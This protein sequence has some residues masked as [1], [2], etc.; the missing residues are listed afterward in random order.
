MF[1]GLIEGRGKIRSIT[2]TGEDLN[3]IIAPLFDVTDCR[4]GDS[5]CV[6]G[7]CLTVTSV[8]QGI[9]SMYASEET[10]SRST[11]GGLKRGD[12]VNMERAMTL[13]ARL[14]GHIVSGHVDGVGII[15]RKVQV[16]KSWVIKVGVDEGISRYTIE[17]GSIAVDGIS[18][19]INLCEDRFFEVNIIPETA[20]IATILRKNVGDPVNIETDLI[21]KYIEKFMEKDSK[22]GKDEAR[23]AIDRK[24]LERFGFAD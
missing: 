23:S 3:L 12:E 17:K 22:S 4:R 20:A 13:S 1:T 24:M 19:T 8:K 6:D 2:K 7:V 15:L 10:V 18:L 21:A 16:Q 9:L 14:G 5:I 11:L